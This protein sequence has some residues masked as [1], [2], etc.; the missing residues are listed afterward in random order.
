MDS[1]DIYTLKRLVRAMDADRKV[2]WL[3][4]HLD[5]KRVQRLGDYG[6]ITVLWEVFAS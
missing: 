2:D 1:G 6:Y 4:L 3:K 5:T